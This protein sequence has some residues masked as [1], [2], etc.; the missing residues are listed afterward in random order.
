MNLK[1]DSST[2]NLKGL[3][4]DNS[5]NEVV[6]RL[7]AYRAARDAA[8][9][10]GQQLT[11]EAQLLEIQAARKRAQSALVYKEVNEA[12]PVPVDEL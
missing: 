3:S 2:F 4:M 11:D 5:D 6:G 12:V 1:M 10:L 7:E 9:R 8:A